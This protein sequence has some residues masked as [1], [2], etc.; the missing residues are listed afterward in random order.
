MQAYGV[1]MDLSCNSLNREDS[2]IRDE[3]IH[4]FK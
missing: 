2:V 4:E 3:L 1:G